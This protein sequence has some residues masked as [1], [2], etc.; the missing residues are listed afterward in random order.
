[1]YEAKEKCKNKGFKESSFDSLENYLFDKCLEEEGFL[2]KQSASKSA[3]SLKAERA[4]ASKAKEEE[5][6]KMQRQKDENARQKKLSKK[7]L[8]PAVSTVSPKVEEVKK[9]PE[10]AVTTQVI[11]EEKTIIKKESK[12]SEA[13][14]N[15]VYT[16]KT[17]CKIDENGGKVCMYD[18]RY[19]LNNSGEL[20]PINK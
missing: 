9:V 6:L 17:V 14:K 8:P 13:N 12:P 4:R 1:M 5:K 19:K 18:P 11:S 2:N 10:V 16:K 3:V 7:V 20:N 15:V